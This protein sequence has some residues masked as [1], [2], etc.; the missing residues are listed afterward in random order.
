MND[1]LKKALVGYDTNEKVSVLAGDVRD[2]LARL[3]K[4]EKALG[5][6]SEIIEHWDL[7]KT[8]REDRELLEWLEENASSD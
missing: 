3:E 7:S 5:N 6:V 2:L 8:F 1:R 4:A